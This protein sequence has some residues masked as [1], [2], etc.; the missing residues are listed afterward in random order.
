M[1][2]IMMH[3]VSF[4]H[5]GTSMNPYNRSPTLIPSVEPSQRFLMLMKFVSPS[6]RRV[7]ILAVV[8]GA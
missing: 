5:G 6:D 1:Q 7:L 8:M 2:E 3:L 4:V